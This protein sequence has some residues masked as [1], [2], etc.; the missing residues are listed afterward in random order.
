[1]ALKDRVMTEGMKLAGHPALAPLLRDPRFMKL[2]MQALAVPGRLEELTEEQKNN[3]IRSLGL[4][5]Q[6][7][8][9]DLKRTVRALEE[10]VSRLRNAQAAKATTA[11][12]ATVS[13]DADAHRM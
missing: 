7:D 1:M 13:A 11:S 8:V 9:D 4:A 12:A 3:F 10:E 2:L 6:E 5:R